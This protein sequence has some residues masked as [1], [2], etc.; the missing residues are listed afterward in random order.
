MAFKDDYNFKDL[1][2]FCNNRSL[3][4]RSF[5]STVLYGEQFKI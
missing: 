1:E 4:H 5:E 3:V 2:S